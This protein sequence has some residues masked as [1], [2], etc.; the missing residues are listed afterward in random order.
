MKRLIPLLVAVFFAI[1]VPADAAKQ[2]NKSS[3]SSSPPS[4]TAKAKSKTSKL[5]GTVLAANGHHAGRA[6]V[7]IRKA[8]SRRGSHPKVNAA[9]HFSAKLKAGNYV[10]SA[11]KRSLGSGHTTVAFAS[12]ANATVTVRLSGHARHKH[13]HHHLHIHIHRH[14]HHHKKIK[15]VS[16]GSNTSTVS[17]GGSFG[18]AGQVAKPK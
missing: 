18:T 13:S 12:G 8:G 11:S 4:N 5:V 9:G 14:H 17:S 2:K 16:P 6:R 10:V 1:A 3:S 7:T 15:I